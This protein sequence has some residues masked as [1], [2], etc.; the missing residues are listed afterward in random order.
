L[1]NLCPGLVET[2]GFT[3]FCTNGP[4]SFTLNFLL[5]ITP[6]SLVF[7]TLVDGAF[8][9]FLGAGDELLVEEESGK[10]LIVG[11]FTSLV[12]G[13]K[14][15]TVVATEVLEKGQARDVKVEKAGR[16]VVEEGTGSG[17]VVV[18]GGAD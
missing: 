6:D 7:C 2:E 3:D 16:S 13:I 8:E 5:T 14:A 10:I 1:K 18:E 17:N 11:V 15:D 4:T 12:I 9:R